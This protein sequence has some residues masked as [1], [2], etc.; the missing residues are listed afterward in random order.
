MFVLDIV[1]EHEVI[2]RALRRAEMQ[3]PCQTQP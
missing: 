1:F 2:V 3:G